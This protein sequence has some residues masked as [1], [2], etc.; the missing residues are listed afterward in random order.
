MHEQKIKHIQ[1][2]LSNT[3]KSLKQ[4]S[5]DSGFINEYNFN[6]FFKKHAGQTPGDYRR[7]MPNKTTSQENNI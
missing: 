7:S 4:I 6:S 1:N 5:I 3:E 2:L